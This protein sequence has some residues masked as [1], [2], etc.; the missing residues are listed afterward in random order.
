MT[1]HVDLESLCSR[2][3]GFLLDLWGVVMD[4]VRAFPGALAWLGRRCAERKPVWFLS[5]A[6]RTTEATTTL[7][8]NLSISRQ[9]Y[10]GA[11]TSGQLAM[12]ALTRPA[13]SIRRG[14]HLYRRRDPRPERLARTGHGSFH[15][16]V[17]GRRADRRD[18]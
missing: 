7:L 13:W 9:L 15:F 3:D 16:P 2:Y 10:A 18:G 1:D 4:G 11:T 14:R 8:A 17:A 6:S 5:N 12:D